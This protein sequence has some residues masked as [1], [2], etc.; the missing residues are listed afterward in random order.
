MFSAILKV[1][2]P[3][4][5]QG[6]SL[7]DQAHAQAVLEAF[8][9]GASGPREIADRAGVGLAH[10][11]DW[12]NQADNLRTLETLAGLSRLSTSVLLCRY[13]AL[14]A[15]A[16]AR[17]A[18]ESPAGDLTRKACAD[19]LAADLPWPARGAAR[20]ELPSGA[21]PHAPAA[22]APP[23]SEQAILAALE[24]LGREADA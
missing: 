1:I 5:S 20:S 14:A 12:L 6:D 10:L 7:M 13:R 2:R 11:A 22:V 23:P 4:S 18:A 15:T 9:E 19:L 17:L 24:A 16:L 8:A 3:A 21:G